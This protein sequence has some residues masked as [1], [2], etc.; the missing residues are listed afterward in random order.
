MSPV[1]LDV[2]ALDSTEPG[3]LGIGL[4]VADLRH[5]GFKCEKDSNEN[6]LRAG[7]QK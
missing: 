7:H 2:T 1:A 5:K 6:S 4:I 3:L